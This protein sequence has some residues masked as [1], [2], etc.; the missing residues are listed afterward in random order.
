M[1]VDIMCGV[2]GRGARDGYAG[3]GVEESSKRVGYWVEVESRCL[4]KVEN[5][6]NVFAV[7]EEERRWSKACRGL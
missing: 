4:V 5:G 7:G 2:R 3:G 1:P 6:L